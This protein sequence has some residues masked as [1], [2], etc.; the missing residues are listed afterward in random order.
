[1]KKTPEHTLKVPRKFNSPSATG[2]PGTPQPTDPANLLKRNLKKKVEVQ[3]NEKVQEIPKNLSP[4]TLMQGETENG[5]PV[6]HFVK[7][8]KKPSKENI[9]GSYINLKVQINPVL[10]FREKITF[11]ITCHNLS[12]KGFLS[13]FSKICLYVV[14]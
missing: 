12:A 3:F 14:C 5:S 7:M 6:D 9:T 10:K 11:P 2:F 4:Y 8:N 13:L 1:M